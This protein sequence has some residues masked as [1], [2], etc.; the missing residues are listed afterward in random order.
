M[1]KNIFSRQNF[2]IAL[3]FL[4]L[5]FERLLTFEL[6]GYTLKLSYLFGLLII[7]NVLLA[8]ITKKIIPKFHSEEVWLLLF[9]AINYI[10]I[11]WSIDPR[12]SLIIS[13]A[14][15]LVISIFF[16]LR[17]LVKPANIQ[18]FEKL[19]IILGVFTSLFAVWQFIAG[20]IPPFTNYALLRAQYQSQ[21]FGF[22]RV[23]S[24]FL[25]PLLFANFLIL[26]FFLA[27]KKVV[28]ANYGSREARTLSET[29]HSQT[30]SKH[31][32]DAKDYLYLA[33]I[34]LA[35]FLTLSRGAGYALIAAIILLG[36][37]IVIKYQRKI[38][39]YGIGLGAVFA[40]V[41]VAV[42]MIYLS[43][44]TVGI[45]NYFGHATDASTTTGEGT[46]DRSTTS[47]V[48][49][50][51]AKINPAGVGA[52]AF[53]ALPIYKDQIPNNGYQIVNNEYLEILVETGIAGLLFFAL[54]L[55]AFVVH[56]IKEI[57]AGSFEAIISLV[58]VA[59]ILIQYLTFST[60]YMGHLWAF[61]A[62]IWPVSQF[63]ENEKTI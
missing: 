55:L 58:A 31:N 45:N 52:G 50:G 56:L 15:T 23:Q 7:L 10:S 32:V 27:F 34:S 22:P 35:F 14:L 20:S 13:L 16:V 44:G 60:I 2:L 54:F 25:E 42:I 49:L 28:I 53:G 17:R 40:G 21:I 8:L 6:S 11:I 12:R 63:K 51:V 37:I 59:A 62:F 38:K 4:S 61:L 33:L 24:T 5:P 30:R 48:A 43:A 46:T 9:L 19:I 1:N 26:P 39:G 29:S 57:K 47:E 41:M 3:F 18:F 36:V